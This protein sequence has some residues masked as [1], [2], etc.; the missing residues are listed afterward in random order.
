MGA[1]NKCKIDY[2]SPFFTIISKFLEIAIELNNRWQFLVTVSHH[3]TVDKCTFKMPKG[4]TLTEEEKTKI[5]V[6]CE[7]KRS[8]SFIANKNKRSRRVVSNFIKNS[9]LYGKTKSAGR[10]PKLTVPARRRLLREAFKEN[11][12]LSK[13]IRSI[14]GFLFRVYTL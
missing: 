2:E 4:R 8:V 11:H 13:Y 12:A 5:S 9:E 10:P 7:D 1:E 3:Q 6:Y 14:K